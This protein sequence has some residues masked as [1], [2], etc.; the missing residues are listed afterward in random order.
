MSVRTNSK[1]TYILVYKMKLR[2]LS[3]MV[4]KDYMIFN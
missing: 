2:K 1:I 4:K 3:F